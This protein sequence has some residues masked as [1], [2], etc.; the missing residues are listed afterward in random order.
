MEE[1]SGMGLLGLGKHA[2]CGGTLQVHVDRVRGGDSGV[3][4]CGGVRVLCGVRGG[5]GWGTTWEGL[6]CGGWGRSD[7][8]EEP[9]QLGGVDASEKLGEVAGVGR[10]GTAWEGRRFGR[11]G[12]G[13]LQRR[14]GSGE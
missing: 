9:L 3:G 12:I 1:G 6:G 8:F 14:G 5:V 11:L 10:S 7:G 4:P 2:R 13:C